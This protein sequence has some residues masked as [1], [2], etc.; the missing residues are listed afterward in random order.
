MHTVQWCSTD[1]GVLAY[2]L[3]AADYHLCVQVSTPQLHV[4]ELP[5]LLL[6][7]SQPYYYPILMSNSQALSIYNLQEIVILFYTLCTVCLY[8]RYFIR[9]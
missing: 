5:L 8:V 4:E 9:M 3:T 2:T 6:I 1:G 7:H